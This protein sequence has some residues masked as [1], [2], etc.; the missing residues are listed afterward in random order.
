MNTLRSSDI[1]TVI[2]VDIAPLQHS[3]YALGT[4][5][6]LI[7]AW[8]SNI[9]E[10]FP[11]DSIDQQDKRV[12]ILHIGHPH[13]NYTIQTEMKKGKLNGKAII[14]SP[15]NVVVGKI[16]YLNGEM[17]G[18]CKL[19]NESGVL[20][21]KGFLHDGYRQGK[22]TEYDTNG[23]VLFDGLFVGG[24]REY[25]YHKV[26]DMEGYWAE[27]EEDGSVRSIC[28]I[29]NNLFKQ[30]VC[31]FYD[32]SKIEQISEWKDNVVINMIK[33]FKDGEMIEYKNGVKSYVGSYY[34]IGKTCFIRVSGREYDVNGENVVYDGDF[35]DGK[36]SGFGI[37]YN[38]KGEVVYDGVWK[39]GI[40]SSV[41]ICLSYTLFMI[42]FF[43]L[44]YLFIFIE[45]DIKGVGGLLFWALVLAIYM[46][47]KLTEVEVIPV[48]FYYDENQT[49]KIL[50]LCG[51]EV[52][53]ESNLN[54]F[55]YFKIDGLRKMR[56]L[57]LPQMD[58]KF[59]SSSLQRFVRIYNCEELEEIVIGDKAFM[60][61]DEFGL[62][63]L[64]SLEKIR[65]GDIDHES[66]NFQNSNFVLRGNRVT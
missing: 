41:Y 34:A 52:I 10:Q 26:I 11:I 7:Q 29:D 32:H 35:I 3:E 64:P 25:R 33:R 14:K 61:F 13:K 49:I 57:T 31:L 48:P 20:F 4:D 63:D 17:T 9:P 8:S 45:F 21:F 46:Y 27:L 54:E 16:H 62:R 59:H 18:K 44:L 43:A 12:V 66:R 19:Y 51:R 55:T 39:Y 50:Y 30:G 65:I 38:S 23:K 37:L 15:T 42:V 56:K 2:N 58:Y 40:K 6:N 1:T 36:R 24:C 22:G 5:G 28:Q 60:Y 53:I 47:T